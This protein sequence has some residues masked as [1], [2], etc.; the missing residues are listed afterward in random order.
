[1]EP[2][3][4]TVDI[5]AGLVRW[6][7]H[8]NWGLSSNPCLIKGGHWTLLMKHVKTYQCFQWEFKYDLW[9]QSPSVTQWFDHHGNPPSTSDGNELAVE[10]R[11]CQWRRGDWCDKRKKTSHGNQLQWVQRSQRSRKKKST[12]IVALAQPMD[13]HLKWLMRSIVETSELCCSWSNATGF[14]ALEVI[15]WKILAPFI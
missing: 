4:G 15:F 8:R 7:N 1:M 6:E 14:Y 9:W 13:N 11:F 2:S 5:N 12:P 10:E 3:G